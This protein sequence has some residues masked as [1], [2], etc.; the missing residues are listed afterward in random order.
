MKSSSIEFLKNLLS[1]G[2]PLGLSL[3][4][5]LEEIYDA[6]GEEPDIEK[7]GDDEEYIYYLFSWCQICFA[8]AKLVKIEFYVPSLSFS[9]MKHLKFLQKVTLPDLISICKKF[10]IDAIL[11]TNDDFEETAL[12]SADRKYAFSFDDKGKLNRII[13]TDKF[14]V[15]FREMSVL[16]YDPERDSIY[17]Y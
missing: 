1:I 3:S 16:E 5:S 10:N 17:I 6:F 7:M 11:M 8:N 12:S 14:L 15:K 13:S 2:T 9:P 4:S